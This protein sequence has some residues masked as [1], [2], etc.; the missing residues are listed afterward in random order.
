[1]ANPRQSESETNHASDSE[2]LVNVKESEKL[3]TEAVQCEENDALLDEIE[4]SLNEDEKT[5]DPVSEKLANF[6]NKRWFQKLR[7]DQL[8]EKLENYYGPENCE[9]LAM[10]QV[11]PEIWGSSKLTVPT[12]AQTT[13]SE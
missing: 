2:E 9:K 11:N 1:M 6:A 7:D 5:D 4:H 3:A 8:N 13:L 12:F 10:T